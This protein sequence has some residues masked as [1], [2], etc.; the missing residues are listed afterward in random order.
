MWKRNSDIFPGEWVGT[1]HEKELEKELEIGDHAKVIVNFKIILSILAKNIQE[2]LGKLGLLRKFVQMMN[3]R[4]SY[5]L[6]TRCV[7]IGLKDI[8]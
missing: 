1:Y 3:G 6:D 7:Q 8:P 5:H 2:L 4:I